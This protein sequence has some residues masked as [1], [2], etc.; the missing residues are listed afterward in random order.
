TLGR[1]HK[2]A[3][4]AIQSSVSV[5]LR[6]KAGDTVYWMPRLK[7]GMTRKM[8][9]LSNSQCGQPPAFS[10]PDVSEFCLWFC[11]LLSK[12][13]QGDRV[14]TAPAASHAK[15]AYERT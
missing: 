10:R 13:A 11:P 4:R 8:I 12:R 6:T 2:F 5:L 3:C 1:L 14:H 15:K 9:Q 7:R